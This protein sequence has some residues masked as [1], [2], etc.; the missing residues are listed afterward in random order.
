MTT[1]DAPPGTAFAVQDK[2]W[3]DRDIFVQWFDHFIKHVHPSKQ[4]PVLQILDGR[5][6]RTGNLEAIEKAEQ[7]GV[8]ML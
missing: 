2:G 1:C 4:A 7:N 5:V 8:V 3:M 6:S